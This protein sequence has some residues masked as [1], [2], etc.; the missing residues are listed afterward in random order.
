ML[1]ENETVK[2]FVNDSRRMAVVGMFD[3]VHRG[4]VFLL[5]NL[6]HESQRR[7]LQP[8]VI[9]FPR[10]PLAVIAPAKAPQLLCDVAEKEAMLR[11][12]VPDVVTVEFDEQL[13]NTSA[14]AFLAKLHGA[15]GVDAMLLGFN[16]RFGHDA[17]HNFEAYV[18]IGRN[19]GV[20]IVRAAEYQQL[21]VS[22]SVSSSEIRRLLQKEGNVSAA[23]QLL[24][25][26]YD[27]AGTVVSG[28]QIGRTIGFP[29]ANLQVA[30]ASKLV[31]AAGVYAAY[32]E[33]DSNHRHIAAVVNIGSCPTVN[34]S[35]Q[36]VMTIE[37]HLI[38]Y[39]ADLYGHDVKLWFVERL[40]SEQKFDSLESL[41]QQI[42]MDRATA[43]ALLARCRQTEV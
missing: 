18:E 10:H 15:Y 42:A 4:H 29:T 36:S 39:H 23:A 12:I 40:R 25:R 35:G 38:D 32:A 17:P 2:T 37:A 9:T 7:N 1:K 16:N 11:R 33:V 8:L 14:A 41:Q 13:R 5:Q 30:D 20:E 27:V 31:P 28:R 24:G 21:E 3:G 43:I 22:D 6:L 19:E 26:C 34:R